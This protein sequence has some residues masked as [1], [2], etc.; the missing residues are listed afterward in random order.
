MV[1]FIKSQSHTVIEQTHMSKTT[2]ASKTSRCYPQYK[3]GKKDRKE[4]NR[5]L[6]I[7]PNLFKIFL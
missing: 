1:Y 2:T 5:P 6:S 7:L 3:K 4:N